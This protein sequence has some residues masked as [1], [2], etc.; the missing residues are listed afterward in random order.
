MEKSVLKIRDAIIRNVHTGGT[1]PPSFPES[2]SGPSWG[3]KTGG[4]DRVGTIANC[5]PLKHFLRKFGDFKFPLNPDPYACMDAMG[6]L[7][8][9]FSTFSALHHAINGLKCEPESL[10]S[11]P[12]CP[13]IWT[14]NPWCP[15]LRP[16]I[17]PLTR[18]GP[19]GWLCD[20][21]SWPVTPLSA[22]WL[23][24]T[25]AN[26]PWPRRLPLKG[27][28]PPVRTP[29]AKCPMQMGTNINRNM[30]QQL[31]M[32]GKEVNILNAVVVH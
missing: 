24:V 2:H 17:R 22:A 9:L 15:F 1:V 7:F 6:F 20:R 13:F 14:W 12:S 31:W 18:T 30:W 19:L 3:K 8:F 5:P 25:F 16:L 11:L 32:N 23:S 10:Q 29:Q 27:N 28:Q 4:K 26:F 21:S